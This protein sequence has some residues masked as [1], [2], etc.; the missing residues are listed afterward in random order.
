MAT[1]RMGCGNT[2]NPEFGRTT[3]VDESEADTALTPGVGRRRDAKAGHMRGCQK[4]HAWNGRAR[5]PLP[6]HEQIRP[7]E[8]DFDTS[9]D[10]IEIRSA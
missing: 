1:Q 10:D 9:Q 6:L 3:A 5:G 2:I 7:G 4:M 8:R